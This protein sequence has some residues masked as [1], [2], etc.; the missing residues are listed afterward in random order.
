MVDNQAIYA[1][2][3]DNR[4]IVIPETIDA[5]RRHRKR[6]GDDQSRAPVTSP[7]DPFL[8]RTRVAYFSMEMA[9]ARIRHLLRRTRH[10]GRRHRPVLRRPGAA[11]RVRDPRQPDGYVRQ[12]IDADGPAGR[13]DPTHAEPP[14]WATPLGAMAA[15]RIEGRPVWV[16]RGSTADLPDRPLGPCPAA[17]HA[18]RAQRS[19]RPSDHLPPTAAT[20]PT[21]SSRKSCSVSAAS[22]AARARLQCGDPII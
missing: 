6:L 13:A 10:P 19:V 12:E 9:L 5:I 4:A 20:T 11:G 7:I 15:V 21:G 16:G 22:A 17:R 18:A 2:T 1:Y 8:P 3:P 14:D